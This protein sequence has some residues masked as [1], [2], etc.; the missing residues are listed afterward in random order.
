MEAI[1]L[2]RMFLNWALAN[3]GAEHRDYLGMSAIGQC[4]LRLYKQMVQGREWSTK[5]HLYCER[6]YAE[7]QR[8]LMKL[9]ALDGIDISRL[10]LYPYA[11]FRARLN[12]LIAERQGCL[13]PNRE[14]VD[15]GGRFQGHSDG[16]W[17]GDLL[18]I[19]SVTQP[20]LEAIRADGRLPGENYYQV[21][22]MM[23]YGGYSRAMMVY[24]ARDTGEM[25][26]MLARRNERAGEAMRLKAATVLEAVEHKTPP[27]CECRWCEGRK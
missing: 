8:A 22:C 16:S 12:E 20:K 10:P 18:E 27:E 19:K 13:G 5:D 3:S 15:F 26:M 11:A 4:P 1:E 17:D 24:V 23:H 7:E 21:Q 6:G 14:F 25:Q 9:A 2:K